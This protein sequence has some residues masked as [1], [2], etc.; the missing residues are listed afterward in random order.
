MLSQKGDDNEVQVI[1]YASMSSRPSQKSMC[2]YS[3]TKIELMALKVE[4][5]Q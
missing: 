2:N 1:A 3:S 5:V 4:C